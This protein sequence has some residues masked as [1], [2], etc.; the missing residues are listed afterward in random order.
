[1]K[2]LNQSFVFALIFGVILSHV[3]CKD[4]ENPTPT[5]KTYTSDIASKWGTMT[6]RI[7]ENT[8]GNSPTYSSRGFGYIGLTMYESVVNGSSIHQSV[9]SQLSDAPVMPKPQSGAEYDWALCLNAGQASIIKNI[10]EQAPAFFKA[11][12]DSLETAFLAVQS[13]GLSTEVVNRSVQY[14]QDVAKAIYEW[15]KGD[16]GHQ[17]YARNFDLNYAYPT[18]AGYWTPP[19][20]SQSASKLPLHPTWG[21]NRTFVPN[22]GQLPIPAMP[23]TYSFDKKSGYYAQFLEVYARQQTLTRE[24]K[25]TALWWSDDPSQTFT[26]PGH[27]Y[28]LA[29]IAVKTAKADLFKAA[30]SFARVGM[31]IGDAFINCWKAKYKYHSERPA[32]FIIPNIEVT[33]R[34]FWPEPPFPAFYSGHA[35][36]GA[37]C[38]TVLTDIY[39]NYFPFTD[40]SHEGRIDDPL[41]S[42]PFISR[43]YLS[44]WEAAEEGATSRLLGGIHCSQDNEIGLQ[45]GRK[46][47]RNVNLLKW[48]KP[49]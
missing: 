13:Q 31:A 9:A 17:G 25:L 38:A 19:A 7:A 28:S 20:F 41:V 42:L 32:D 34:Q 44:F 16:G 2:L 15:S 3:G 30:E 22:N 47:G 21:R 45:E 4:K 18:G 37:S 11:K 1:M 49:L 29:N 35:T 43:T 10:Y 39:G 8:A 5:P 14:G 46:V 36:N 26:P 12:I 48:R 40:N 24:E 27:S 23:N 33:F 6:L